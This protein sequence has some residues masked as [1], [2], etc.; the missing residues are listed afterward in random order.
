MA[1]RQSASHRRCHDLKKLAAMVEAAGYAVV[2][3]E[4]AWRASPW[5]EG[6]C[7]GICTSGKRCNNGGRLVFRKGLFC[8]QHRNQAWKPRKALE[9]SQS[10]GI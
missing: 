1:T 3:R 5:R 2:P 10:Q 8:F 6:Q 9:L 7:L 4:D